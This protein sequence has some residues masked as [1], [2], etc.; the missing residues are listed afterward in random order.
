MKNEDIFK[1]ADD[2]DNYEVDEHDSVSGMNDI[3]NGDYWQIIVDEFKNNKINLFEAEE[4]FVN[5]YIKQFKNLFKYAVNIPIRLKT[6][7][8]PKY[9][10]IF[11]TNNQDG[12]ILM[13]DNM[14]RRWKELLSAQR[15]GQKVLF[16]YEF[17]DLSIQQN[18]NLEKDILN[19]LQKHGFSVLMKELL[20]ELIEKYGI[21]FSEKEYKDKMREMGEKKLIIIN[22]TPKYTPKGKEVTSLDYKKYSIRVSVK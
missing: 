14:N 8:M 4:H 20:V 18:F 22:R 1:Y 19:I 21:S 5:A 12:A 11:G 6:G 15:G 10:L 2:E 16:E 9:R 3:A 7:H 17:P 13:A